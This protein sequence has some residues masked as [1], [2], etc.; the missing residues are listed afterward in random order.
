MGNVGSNPSSP[1]ATARPNLL[2]TLFILL[3]SGAL[4]LFILWIAFQMLGAGEQF[5]TLPDWLNALVGGVWSWLTASAAGVVLYWL[6]RRTSAGAPTPHYL[7]WIGGVSIFL[8][9]GVMGVV[10]MVQ[11]V[12]A[13]RG[14]ANGLQGPD[15]FEVDFSFR[16]MYSSEAYLSQDQL[17]MKPTRP[18]LL[19]SRYI[20]QQAMGRFVERIDLP[21]P[22]DFYHT[23][24]RRKPLDSFKQHI[25]AASELCFKRAASNPRDARAAAL[26]DCEEGQMC[27]IS[28]Q[29]PGWAQPCTPEF[30]WELPWPL[31]IRSVW[32]Q[33]ADLAQQP[34]WVVPSLESLQAA[35]LSDESGYT[36]FRVKGVNLPYLNADVIRY[37]VTVNRTPVRIDGFLP[38]E[39]SLP[40]DAE[41]GIHIEFGL[42]NLDF[43]GA[44]AGRDTV[45]LKIALLDGREIVQEYDLKLCYVALRSSPE[46]IYEPSEGTRFQWDATYVQASNEREYEVFIYSTRD[47][48]D[49]EL[50]RSQ[51]SQLEWTYQ[52]GSRIQG[53][54]RPSL[55]DN[56]N[57]GVAVGLEQSSGRIRFTFDQPTAR[58]LLRWVLASRTDPRS[59]RIVRHDSH[60]YRIGT[61]DQIQRP[62]KVEQ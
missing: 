59:R 9:L 18:H 52:D 44:N 62:C 36:R 13:P 56:P 38:D 16:M 61:R 15:R 11:M 49:A 1:Q 39:L 10:V 46:Q 26:F 55:S 41:K 50:R 47:A 33:A 45:G 57:Y 24:L 34:V 23:I 42:Q 29:D 43:R 40:Y 53:V 27:T 14:T 8:L 12:V 30:S 25:V 2:D 28:E 32:A 19:A 22:N 37:E 17:V 54:T 20:T 5:G 4:V 48:R 21:E 51:L 60:L 7:R 58:S 31:S 35:D 3:L 6:R